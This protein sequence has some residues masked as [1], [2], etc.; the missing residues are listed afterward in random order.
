MSWKPLHPSSP[1]ECVSHEFG[2]FSSL[3]L[4]VGLLAQLSWMAAYAGE[5]YAS[6]MEE[7]KKSYTRY[8]D[9][10]KKVVH[11]NEM[12]PR[13]ESFFSKSNAEQ[14]HG[15]AKVSRSALVGVYIDRLA[16]FFVFFFFFLLFL[17][18]SQTEFVAAPLA[19]AGLFTSNTMPKAVADVYEHKC[20]PPPALEKMDPVRVCASVLFLCA[21]SFTMFACDVY[22]SLPYGRSVLVYGRGQEVPGAIHEPSFLPVRVDSRAGEAAQGCQG[23]EK[24]A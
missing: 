4:Q 16:L 19:D 24:E 7:S 17:L 5:V 21:F 1:S 9:V 2:A 14:L 8:M 23:G 10:N 18:R 13:I 12:L 11:L 22:L 6:I 15:N 20:R 3:F